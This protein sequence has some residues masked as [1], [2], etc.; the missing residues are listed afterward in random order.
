M[1]SLDFDDVE[2]L[3]DLGCGD[4]TLSE[5][6]VSKGIKVSATNAYN[7][8]PERIE[9][10]NIDYKFALSDNLP[11]DDATFDA[12]FFS[13]VLEH[14]SDWGTAIKEIRRV[15]KPH[16][17]VILIVP[18]YLNYVQEE[19]INIGWNLGQLMYVLLTLG[20]QVKNGNF[21]HYGFNILAVAHKEDYTLPYT[22][23]YKRSLLH[24]WSESGFFPVKI[25]PYTDDNPESGFWG[26]YRSLNWPN[27]EKL[28]WYDSSCAQL[29]NP[30]YLSSER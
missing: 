22:D 23:R 1:E 4:G 17:R 10:N 13:H 2:S 16:G 19:H 9:R 26:N 18:P 20:F 5:Y 29:Y 14:I 21:I 11:F 7:Q 30:D 27:P 15:L 25:F 6:F 28:R 12:V 24:L 3:L 8:L